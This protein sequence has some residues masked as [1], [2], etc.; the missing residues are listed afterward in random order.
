MPAF[1]W[2]LWVAG[3]M[4][5]AGVAAA[6]APLTSV[7]QVN[8][9]SL[10][11]AG[12]GLPVKFSAAV[13]HRDA[14]WN[15]LFVQ[16][17]T[18]SIYVGGE[19]TRDPKVRPG[20]VLEVEGLTEQGI[21]QP[22]VRARRWTVTGRV[23]LPP[24]IDLSARPLLSDL[25]DTRRVKFRG[26]IT[27]TTNAA[28]RPVLE[29][30]LGPGQF[31]KMVGEGIAA[32]S[33]E[34]MRGTQVEVEGVFAIEVVGNRERT[35]FYWLWVSEP[36]QIKALRPLP[37]TSTAD[38]RAWTAPPSSGEPLRV[39]GQVVSQEPGV[40]L[41]VRDE[42]G[43]LR[44]AYPETRAWVA[45][46]RVEVFAFAVGIPS[47]VVF[48]NTRVHSVTVTNLSTA[49]VPVPVAADTRLPEL[50]RVLQVRD[51][52]TA[53]SARGYPIRLA[54]VVT[55]LDPGYGLIFLQDDSSGIFVNPGGKQFELRAGQRVE[56]RGFSGPGDFAPV[57]HADDIRVLGAGVFPAV[58]P[59]A[60]AS[61]MNGGQD[62]QW[63]SVQGVVRD[64]SEENTRPALALST[65]EGVLRVNLPP[66]A[67]PPP[68][69]LV[70]ARVEIRGVC[71]TLFDERRQIRGIQFYV[72]GWSQVRVQ[73]A[74]H[75]DA[76]AQPVIPVAELLRFRPEAQALN[77]ARVQGMVTHR[78]SGQSIYV[79][80]RSGAIE[81]DIKGGTNQFAAGMF[82]DVSGFPSV[83]DRLPVLQDAVARTLTNGPAITPARLEPEHALDG[84]LHARLVELE[85]RVVGEANRGDTQI[86]TVQFGGQAIDALWETNA[87]GLRLPMP[88]PGSVT[89]LTGIYIAQLDSGFKARTF[90][91]LLR[92]TND[93][94]IVSG[95]AWWT[96][97]HTLA[98]IGGLSLC[99]FLVTAWGVALRR[100]VGEQTRDLRARLEREEQLEKQFRELFEHAN[101][102]IYTH[103]LAGNFT[104]LN[105]AGLKL[106]GYT[107]AE[108][109]GLNLRAVVAPEDQPLVTA[110]LAG[111]LGAGPAANREITF[112]ARDGRRIHLE[113]STRV[114]ERAYKPAGIHGIARDI[115]ERKRAEKDLREKE[116]F[117]RSVIDTDPNLIFVK[118]RDGRFI[119]VNRANAEHHDLTVE[120]MTGA[121]EM[122]IS[123]NPE[124][125]RAFQKDDVEV[126]DTR[127]EKVVREERFTTS[128][129]RVIWLQT[130]KRPLISPDGKARYVLGVCT[131]ITAR[132]Q[133]EEERKRAEAFLQTVLQN[134]PIMVFIKEARELRHVLW[135]KAAEEVSGWSAAEIMGKS[136]QE[137]HSA[138]DAARC[139]AKDREILATGHLVDI[140][141]E[142]LPTRHRGI[143]ILHTRKIPIQAGDGQM[144]YL[145]GISEDITERK[146]EEEELRQAKLA[147][148][149]A[150]KAKSEFLANMSHEIRT[151][152]N[153]IIGMTNLLLDTGLNPE[154]RDFAQT[155]RNSAESL[156]GIINDILDF[157]KIEAG[158]LH[159]ETLDFDLREVIE[160]SLDLLSERAN[161][162]QV[163]LGAMVP[164]EIPCHLRGDPGRLR[165]V[166]L[167]LCSNAVK[168]TERGD[169]LVSVAYEEET[170]M[171]VKLR[172][173]VSDTGVGIAPEAQA[174]LFQPFTQADNS[175]T[176]KYGGTGLGLAISKKIVEL[177]RGAIGL[178]SVHGVG[179][180]FWFTAWFEKPLISRQPASPGHDS[181]RS[182]RVLVVDDNETNRRI[183]VHHLASW[184]MENAA[185]AGGLAALEML[186]AAAQSGRPYHLV[187]LDMQMPEMDG[188]K[189]GELI[190]LD[191]LLQGVRVI[192]LT[193][194]GQQHPASVLRSAGIV[195]CLVKPVK[196][197]DL[198]RALLRVLGEPRAVTARPESR[199]A[200]PVPARPVS[201]LRI[202]VAEDNVVNQKVTL[203]QLKRLGYKADSVANGH[204]VLAALNH[205][206]YDVV[207]MDCHMPEMDGYE[208]T[209][210]LRAEGRP[211]RIVAM[212][213]NA[214]QGDREKCLD[215]GMDDYVSKPVRLEDLEQALAK[216]ACAAASQT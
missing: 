142:A 154:Q 18:N 112:V 145:V 209:R 10:E 191:P 176:R 184:Q 96:L 207:L 43:E 14:L 160:T 201:S 24:A 64:L 102:F 140:P 9:L 138:A 55:Y 82:V 12:Q 173:A 76:F 48:T 113:I 196:Q 107:A 183:L 61:L 106:L 114:I 123:P 168:F 118:D 211:I 50:R 97:K 143:R 185:A 73:T 60:V 53:E 166:L 29:L 152:M 127:R 74:G 6:E 203:H 16:A 171:E 2:L 95:V 59:V 77:R 197:T 4:T 68:A 109:A 151:P 56:V 90:R 11:T 27:A 66:G 124:E 103:D 190:R 175:T 45:G 188:F 40:H 100:K 204:E 155:S 146:R 93:V 121:L 7:A 21:V 65:G 210:R 136:D 80:D 130:V 79:Q 110:L 78:Q 116:E 216:C 149:S 164:G 141:E 105:P 44:F 84:S 147:A 83:I 159:F 214:M 89:R 126:M 5:M 156:L 157:S 162:R 161:Q 117:I 163:E 148:E 132:K 122:D 49:G 88:A 71:A 92:S 144:A 75:E 172:F 180:T 119:L 22:D 69:S 47:G 205:G 37:V 128:S 198:Y 86:L 30:A 150:S 20:D 212:T 208:A 181:L 67:G 199:P 131:D 192:L 104:S 62:S 202:L 115:S 125:V 194:V 187:V 72:P 33:G 186:R 15:V 129:G 51:L 34:K 139:I 158:K 57:A 137:L 108:A 178:Q 134:L 165:Q 120:R 13:T 101:D 17:G 170:A 63:V 135:N 39:R 52:S 35:G 174:A 3:Q 98:A 36:G 99:V 169:V 46:A 195:A 81:V 8:A 213:A 167:N 200:A 215:V 153:G 182:A 25:L 206:A 193:S 38:A 19:V 111:E 189:V 85:G 28:D 70:D 54:G 32:D 26:V 42:G 31:V 133:E 179:S 91:L 58:R 1:L 23:A 87:A 94:V 41:T 177:M